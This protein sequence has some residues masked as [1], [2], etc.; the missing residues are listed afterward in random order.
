MPDLIPDIIFF[1]AIS[2]N[3]EICLETYSKYYKFLPQPGDFFEDEFFDVDINKQ[4][5]LFDG[6]KEEVYA[7]EEYKVCRVKYDFKEIIRYIIY[8]EPNF[9]RK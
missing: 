1:V 8:V 6:D 3:T 4:M 5:M 9:N 7:F 2:S